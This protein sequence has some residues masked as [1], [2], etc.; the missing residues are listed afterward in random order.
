M[1]R[2]EVRCPKKHQ[3]HPSQLLE[4]LEG[5]FKQRGI[6]RLS[7]CEAWL[8]RHADRKAARKAYLMLARTRFEK[9]IKTTRYFRGLDPRAI[10][11]SLKPMH[12]IVSLCFIHQPIHKEWIAFI[13]CLLEATLSSVQ[14]PGCL[15]YIVDHPTQFYRDYNKPL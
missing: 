4:M 6:S 5:K 13:L 11:V 10:F 9:L 14:N 3:E 8:G 15:L 1:S 2:V 7:S 12:S